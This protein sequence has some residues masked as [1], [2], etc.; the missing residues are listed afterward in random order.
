MKKMTRFTSMA[1][2]LMLVL[3]VALPANL[4]AAATVTLDWATTYQTIDGFGVSEAFIN[5]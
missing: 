1:A 5:Q 2:L 4:Y 3:S